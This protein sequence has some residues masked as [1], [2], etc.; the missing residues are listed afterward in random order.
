MFKGLILCVL[1]SLCGCSVSVTTPRDCSEIHA[2]KKVKIFVTECMKL[3]SNPNRNDHNYCFN[4]AIK[5]HCKAIT[6]KNK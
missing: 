3:I 2:S 1:I 6:R 4:Q 5:L